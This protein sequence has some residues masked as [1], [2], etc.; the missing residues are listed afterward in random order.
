MKVKL[1]DIVELSDAG[2][3]R[4]HATYGKVT[5]VDEGS[6]FIRVRDTE[7]DWYVSKGEISLVYKPTL[8]KK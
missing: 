2:S 3:L 6:V 7:P 4:I 1:G 8:R 5:K